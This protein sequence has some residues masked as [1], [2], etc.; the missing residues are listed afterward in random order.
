VIVGQDELLAEIHP[1]RVEV[2]HPTIRDTDNIL[3]FSF[4]DPPTP[5]ELGDIVF[6][7]GSWDTQ[8]I[9]SIALI[10][11][12]PVLCLGSVVGEMLDHLHFLF[13]DAMREEV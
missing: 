2:Q 3:A 8:E 1:D 4:L 5:D 12:D 11:T 6:V 9:G 7:G 13:E 10:D